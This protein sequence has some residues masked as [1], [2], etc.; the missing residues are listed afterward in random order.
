MPKRRDRLAYRF[1]VLYDKVYRHDVLS[2]AY[3]CCCANGGAPGVD[4][5]SFADIQA[6][7]VNRWLG[8]VAEELRSKMYRPQA[9]RRVWIPK[10]DGK[11]R[12]LGIPTVKD[13]VVQMASVL[14]LE[15]IFE[16]DLQPEQCAYRP[17]RRGL[18][19]AAGH[20]LG[21]VPLDHGPHRGYAPP[22]ADTDAP[23][24]QLAP[25]RRSVAK[26][27]LSNGLLSAKRVQTRRD[28]RNRDIRESR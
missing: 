5:R 14:V 20:R 6:Y 9:V 2:F 19:H 15:P 11:K 22:T 18:R 13:R 12:P 4:D 3:R 8:E 23:H 26:R 27:Q 1:Y 16:A 10:P 7:G 25:I 28:T 17:G 21:S 24:A